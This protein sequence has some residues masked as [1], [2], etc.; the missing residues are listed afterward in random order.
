MRKNR[1]TRIIYLKFMGPVLAFLLA[2]LLKTAN[3]LITKV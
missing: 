2:G 3:T 1:S